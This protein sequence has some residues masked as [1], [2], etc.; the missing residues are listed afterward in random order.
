MSKKI[1]AAIITAGLVAFQASASVNHKIIVNHDFVVDDMADQFSYALDSHENSQ[2]TSQ[3]LITFSKTLESKSKTPGDGL[4]II[5]SRYYDSTNVSGTTAIYGCYSNCH[6][7][8]HSACHGSRGW[9]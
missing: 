1:N 3:S 4:E 8:C 6:S 9:R 2:L 5:L 7:A